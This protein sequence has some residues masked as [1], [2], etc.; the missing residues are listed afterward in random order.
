MSNQ[1]FYSANG[2]LNKKNNLNEKLQESFANLGQSK[3]IAGTWEAKQ[4]MN[5]AINAFLEVSDEGSYE[6]Y[7]NE[8]FP[9]ILIKESTH[10]RFI[11]DVEANIHLIG[12]GGAG[13]SHVVSEWNANNKNNSIVGGGGGGGATVHKLNMKFKK[14]EM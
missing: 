7:F 5:N 14:D 3:L 13:A 10:F 8:G 6:V 2:E 12:G 9:Y 4:Q 1:N 11:D